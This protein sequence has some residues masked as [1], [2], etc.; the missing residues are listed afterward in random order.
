MES[1]FLSKEN[2][3]CAKIILILE[4]SDTFRYSHKWWST[5]KTAFFG[6]NTT[7]PPFLKPD[8]SLTHCPKDK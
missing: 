8:G 5:F 4:A 1:S 2:L 6:V 7:V 3:D